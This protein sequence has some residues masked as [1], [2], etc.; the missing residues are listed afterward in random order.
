MKKYL[1]YVLMAGMLFYALWLPAA[2]Y[3]VDRDDNNDYSNEVVPG[4]EK[5]SRWSFT[6]SAFASMTIDNEGNVTFNCDVTGYMN[7][8]DKIISYVYLQKWVNGEWRN[9][10]LTTSTVYDWISFF[11]EDYDTPV[12]WGYDYRTRNSIYVYVGDEYEHILLYSLVH[13]YH[14]PDG[15]P[16][17][18]KNEEETENQA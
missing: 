2:V 18:S 17:C 8:T 4:R 1:M 9:V 14:D 15:I 5:T 6:D 12:D 10:Y 7:S 13:H 16:D 11:E 3:A